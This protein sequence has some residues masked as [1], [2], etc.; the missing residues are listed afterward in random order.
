MGYI[1][2]IIGGLI[3]IKGIFAIADITT[4][5]PAFVIVGL[6][7]FVVANLFAWAGILMMD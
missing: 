5:D 2:V 7:Y 1:L 4:E 3:A 6:A